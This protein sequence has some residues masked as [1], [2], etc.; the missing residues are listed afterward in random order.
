VTTVQTERLLLRPPE[1]E[2]IDAMA[3][4]WA[5]PEVMR[6][7]G[8]GQTRDRAGSE[9]LLGRFQRHWEEHGFGLWVIVP[10][11]EEKPVGWAGLSIPSFLPAVLPAVE[12]G[13]LLARPAWGRG[14]ATEGALAAR[15]WGFGELALDRLISLIYTEN[16]AS[17]A[18]A[19]RLGM[20]PCEEQAH[21]VT[22]RIIEV[23]EVRP[24]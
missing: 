7:I 21:P 14:Y 17:A 11:G 4:I 22:G 6:H 13:W 2:D 24:A 12:V 15:D 8:E 20:E 3:A 19:R 1:P 16:T 18:V 10:L 9:A 23:F 5:D